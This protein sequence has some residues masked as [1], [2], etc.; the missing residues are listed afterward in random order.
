MSILSYE[1]LSPLKYSK[2]FVINIG[3]TREPTMK[4]ARIETQ[5]P[6]STET[7]HA[8]FLAK[9]TLDEGAYNDHDVFA[10]IQSGTGRKIAR[11]LVLSPIERVNAQLGY[12]LIELR[13]ATI[14]S[15]VKYGSFHLVAR[16]ALSPI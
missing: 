7:F 13:W 3:S 16:N 9:V 5:Y 8:Y 12:D 4:P 2:S 10:D 11:S 14:I 15:S 6:F 1:D